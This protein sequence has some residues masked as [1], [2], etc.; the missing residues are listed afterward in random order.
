MRQNRFR[1]IGDE[2]VEKIE[3]AGLAKTLG[4][5]GRGFHVDEKQHAL[6]DAGPP[7]AAG[8]EIE[9]YA[10]AEQIVHAKEQVEAEAK[11]ERKDYAA[12]LDQGRA[13][14]RFPHEPRTACIAAR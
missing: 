2:T 3:E 11:D 10:L 1:D 6:L 5:N 9:Q 4:D 12:A 14:G 8:D 7:I 13:L